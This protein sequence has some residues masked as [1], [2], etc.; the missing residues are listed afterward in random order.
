MDTEVQRAKIEWLKCA[1]WPP[2]FIDSYVSVYD[3]TSR[4]WIPFKLWPAQVDTLTAM[5][6][7]RLLC[8][9]KARQLGLSWLTLAYVLWEMLYRPAA[10]ALLFS[11]RDDEAIEL[12]DA[13]L[14]GMYIR[15]PAWMQAR[16]C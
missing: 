7:E 2:Y 14:K 12:L 5:Q 8:I 16:Q 1:K 3:A 13:R 11:K 15:L 9:L 4:D 10:T 6:N